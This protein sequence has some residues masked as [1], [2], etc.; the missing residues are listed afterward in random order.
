MDY[1]ISKDKLRTYRE[2]SLAKLRQ[3][4]LT[5][6]VDMITRRVI[7]TATK[8]PS[9]TILTINTDTL[10][11][12]TQVRTPAQMFARMPGGIYDAV[13]T[14]SVHV[15][16]IILKLKERFPDSTITQDANAN[17]LTIDWS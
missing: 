1:P 9:T 4:A 5:A 7:D 12:E 10:N 13:Y 16:A 3:Q 14:Q 17:T 6:S 8:T 11:Q 15:D 2:D